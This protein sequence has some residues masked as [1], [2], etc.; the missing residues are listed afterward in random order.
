MWSVRRDPWV[1]HLF[2]KFFPSATQQNSK[3]QYANL[4]YSM[5]KCWSFT[6][7]KKELNRRWDPH[8]DSKQTSMVAEGIEPTTQGNWGWLTVTRL[9]VQTDIHPGLVRG[10]SPYKTGSRSGEDTP[11][12]TLKYISHLWGPSSTAAREKT[13]VTSFRNWSHAQDSDYTASNG[14]WLRY[15]IFISSISIVEAS[16]KAAT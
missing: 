5:V 1:V 2:L 4:Q 3:N 12:H 13:R 15:E 6:R 14:E 7:F 9:H 8:Q 16:S 11:E 10:F